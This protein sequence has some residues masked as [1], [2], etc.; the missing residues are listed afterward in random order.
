[1][2]CQGLNDGDEG[3]NSSCTSHNK[4]ETRMTMKIGYKSNALQLTTF[5]KNHVVVCGGEQLGYPT[6][7]SYK[8]G[9]LVPGFFGKKTY[10]YGHTICIIG[11][12]ND[13]ELG[14]CL[15]TKCTNNPWK[16]EK[17][18]LLMVNNRVITT[19]KYVGLAVYPVVLLD[20]INASKNR[21]S[22]I[23]DV[24]GLKIKEWP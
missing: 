17:D 24:Y 7:Q 14:P 5:L 13:E 3:L 9:K 22:G 4:Y 21:V 16:S 11:S 18:M 2:G 1:V 10:R 23:S 6:I 8:C 15:V 19:K 12:Y 20:K